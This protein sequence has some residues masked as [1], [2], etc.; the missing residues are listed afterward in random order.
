MPKTGTEGE[1]EGQSQQGR[2]TVYCL[3]QH[4]LQATSDYYEQT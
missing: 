3:V 1:R 4:S 2:L